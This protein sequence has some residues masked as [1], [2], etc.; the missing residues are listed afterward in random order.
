M[1]TAGVCTCALP[2]GVQ[3]CVC[4][5]RSGGA[6]AR[7][8]PER[9][10]VRERVQ[11]SLCVCRCVCAYILFVQLR[12]SVCGVRAERCIRFSLCAAKF[13]CWCAAGGCVCV[14]V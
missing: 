8:R 1:C 12:V 14:C 7:V 6:R 9:W 3:V 5:R 4:V 13:V 10:G 11:V 2:G